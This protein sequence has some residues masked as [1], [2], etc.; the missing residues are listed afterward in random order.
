M[1]WKIV[2]KGKEPICLPL[3]L[4]QKVILYDKLCTILR[5]GYLK[6]E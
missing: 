6:I 4:S 2:G 1:L 3:M 5:S